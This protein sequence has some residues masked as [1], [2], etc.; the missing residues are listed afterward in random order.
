V[1][2][3]G[4]SDGEENSMK[5][6]M[7]LYMASSADFEKAMKNSTPEQHKK[8]MDARMKWMEKRKKSIVD[9]GAP[10]GKTKRVDAKDT[11]NTKNTV[12][13]YSIVQAKSHDDAAKLF[14]KDQ[15]HLQMTSGGWIEIVEIMPI[16]GV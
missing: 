11:S 16:P 13:G 12:G 5:K 7:V 15:P 8:G 9:G 14:G 10:L 1:E 4:E 6:F 3:Q 2:K